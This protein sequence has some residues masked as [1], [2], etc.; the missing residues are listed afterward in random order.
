M[1]IS[2]VIKGD[3]AK[4]MIQHYSSTGEKMCTV[5]LKVKV[6]RE[7]AGGFYGDWFDKVVFAGIEK[8]GDE[9]RVGFKSIT[10]AFVLEKHRIQILDKAISVKPEI[11]K[12]V[13]VEGEEVVT[14]DVVLPLPVGKTMEKFYGRLAL[15]VGT[16]ISVEFAREEIPLPGTE[17]K[18]NGQ[19]KIVSGSPR[20]V[21]SHGPTMR[22]E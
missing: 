9:V 12:V 7:D 10:T 20:P 18:N 13:A 16:T 8:D 3:L 21:G 15:A 14:L 1:E 4:V 11:P 19:L 22:P 2:G 5:T 6:A 17:D